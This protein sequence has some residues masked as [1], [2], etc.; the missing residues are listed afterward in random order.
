MLFPL[1]IALLIAGLFAYSA[2]VA[3]RT[4]ALFPPSGEFVDL[5][6]EFEGLRL[7]YVSR[8]LPLAP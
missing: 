3:W 5:D 1:V 6:G 7:H 8:R 2:W 4:A